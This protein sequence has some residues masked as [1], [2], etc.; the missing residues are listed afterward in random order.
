MRETSVDSASSYIDIRAKVLAYLR[1]KQTHI[2]YRDDIFSDI[3]GS[4][5]LPIKRDLYDG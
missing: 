5:E 4:V 3:Y 1:A 2:Q